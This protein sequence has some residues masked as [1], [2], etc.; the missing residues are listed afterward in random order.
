[1]VI[2]MDDM[3][4]FYRNEFSGYFNLQSHEVFKYERLETV[5][6]SDFAIE[7]LKEKYQQF[8]FKNKARSFMKG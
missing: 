1:M 4:K 3:E 8:V 7:K 5:N 2:R 6:L